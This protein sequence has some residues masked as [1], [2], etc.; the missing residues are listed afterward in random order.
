SATLAE[1][2]PMTELA[3]VKISGSTFV[4]LSSYDEET[5]HRWKNGAVI[6]AEFREVRNPRFHRKFFALVNLAFQ[7]WE[8]AEIEHP[9]PWSIHT[10][11]RLR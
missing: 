4:P 6:R 8:P 9:T 2:L 7:Y 11:K 5:A 10:P 1:D 3:L